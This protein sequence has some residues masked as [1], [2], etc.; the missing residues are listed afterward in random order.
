M[1]RIVD[2]GDAF[3]RIGADCTL[4]TEICLALESLADSLPGSINTDLASRLPTILN[5]SWTEH[6][7]FQEAVIFPILKRHHAH[8]QSLADQIAQLEIEHGTIGDSGQEISEQ[9]ELALEGAE[10]NA[11]M[12]GYM[13]RSAFHDRRRHIEIEHHLFATML[14]AMLAPVDRDL[15]S[16]WLSGHAWP[17][18]LHS[19]E[20]GGH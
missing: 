10:P 14:P 6:V 15:L 1:K 4:Q 11:D 12:I 19:G 2:V 16:G 3:E 20:T 13:L 18:A 5:S 17:L 8:S 9:L 7:G